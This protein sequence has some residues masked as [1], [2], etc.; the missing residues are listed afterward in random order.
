MRQPIADLRLRLR[1]DLG[2]PRTHKLLQIALLFMYPSLARKSI[3][4][5][6]CI[7]AGEG[8]WLLRDDPVLQCYTAQWSVMAAV[9]GGV[10]VCLYCLG[11][12]LAAFLMARKYHLGNRTDERERGRVAMLVT[13]YK[14]ECAKLPDPRSRV[15]IFGHSFTGP[16]ACVLACTG[17]GME[18]R[19]R[20]CT[21]SSSLA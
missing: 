20:C 9:A 6:D 7:P 8:L 14:S 12:P 16:P 19:Y 5:F 2:N 13:A 4:V 18:R 11:L 3:A 15:P 17:T 1:N 10:G 21:D